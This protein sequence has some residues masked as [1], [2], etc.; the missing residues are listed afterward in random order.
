MGRPK[1]LLEYK[2]S[3]FLDTAIGLF[4]G[5][6]SPVIVVL[7]AG[8]E[9]IRQGVRRAATFVFNPDYARGQITSMQ[10]GLR[11]IPPEAGGVLFTLVD[12]PAVSRLTI[13]T[14]LAGAGDALLRIPRYNGKRGHPIWLSRELIPE[15]LALDEDGAARDVELYYR[16]GRDIANSREWPRWNPGT[17]FKTA[18]EESDAL[19]R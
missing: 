12:H 6:C 7:G 8:A 18:R 19:R 2:G 17:E 1:A 14:L 13:E 15:F 9:E 10:A 16:V 11:A 3:T 4:E 5:H